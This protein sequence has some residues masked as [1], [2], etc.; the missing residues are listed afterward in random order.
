M[1]KGVVTF[2]FCS[3]PLNS[4]ALELSFPVC[5]MIGIILL[6]LDHSNCVPPLRS[7]CGSWWRDVRILGTNGL[8]FPGASGEFGFTAQVVF[9]NRGSRQTSVCS[10]KQKMLDPVR[11]IHFLQRVLAPHEDPLDRFKM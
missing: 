9:E 1:V 3:L 8:Q 2:A 11:V 10:Q 5:K 7:C 4:A 6:L